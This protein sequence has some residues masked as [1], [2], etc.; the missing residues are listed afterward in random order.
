MSV[1]VANLLLIPHATPPEGVTAASLD[2][3]RVLRQTL[4][5]LQPQPGHEVHV[6]E[7]HRHLP[8]ELLQAR[9]LGLPTDDGAIPWA[10]LRAAE[11]RLDEQQAWGFIS[12]CHW[13]PGADHIRMHPTD[14]L[15]LQADEAERLREA[16]A[17]WF[18]PEGIRLVTDPDQPARWLACGEPLRDLRSTAPDR[19]IGRNLDLWMPEGPAARLLRRLQS[20]MQMLLYQHPLHDERRARGLPPV[21]S[22]WLHGTGALPRGFRRNEVRITV[23]DALRGPALAQ[24]ADA[25]LDAW[26]PIEAQCLVPLADTQT[27]DTALVLSGEHRA[28]T[29]TIPPSGFWQRLR[30]GLRGDLSSPALHALLS[31]L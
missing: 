28:I 20:E 8:H 26:Q 29:L 9:A 5:R 23:I 12:P 21:N 18:E 31:A 11:L 15:G 17:P 3:L 25:W 30:H 1:P 13:E 14:T 22:F 4:R 16:M 10:A 6:D 27:R 24:D 7:Q 2:T 19:A